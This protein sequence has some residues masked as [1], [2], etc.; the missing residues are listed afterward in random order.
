MMKKTKKI[1]KNQQYDNYWKLTVEYSDIFNMQFNNTLKIIINYIDEVKP[2]EYCKYDYQILQDR[3]NNVYHKE[4]NASTRKSINQFVKLGFVK[5]YLL[6]YHPKTKMFLNENDINKKRIIFS[7]IFY[8]NASFKSSVTRDFTY[9]NEVKFLLKTLAYHPEKK[10]S[11]DDIIALMCTPNISQIKKGYLTENELV[12]QKN[13]ANLI[14]FEEKKYNQI[15]YLF[16]FLNLVDNVDANKNKGIK[17]INPEDVIIDSKRD[18]IRYSIYR[19]ELKKE[20]NRLFGKEL[21]YI[22]MKYT[23][24]LTASHIKD[25]K[26]CLNEGNIDDAYNYENGLLLN[27]QNDMMFDHY[28]ISIQDN[29]RLLINEEEFGENID[30]INKLKTTV[31]D[32]RILTESRKKY[33]AWHRKRF[34][35]KL[36]KKKL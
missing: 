9:Q 16:D 5:P 32:Q 23:K 35:E 25:L 4:D 14:H 10:L 6:G 21:C 31:I 30:Y 13:Y 18:P 27:Q 19:T 24:G 2:T 28:D 3:I 34:N 17:F 26:V 20:S 8:E 1:I 33:L 15:G 22:D 29:G 12:N 11:K 36:L 7:E